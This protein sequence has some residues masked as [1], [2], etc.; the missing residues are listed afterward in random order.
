MTDETLCPC[1]HTWTNQF[2]DDWTP[3]RGTLCDCGRKRWGI[4]VQRDESERLKLSPLEQF[5]RMEGL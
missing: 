5:E 4:P 1:G 3:D 2:G